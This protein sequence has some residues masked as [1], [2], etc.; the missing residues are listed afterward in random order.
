MD[1]LECRFYDGSKGNV[2]CSRTMLSIAN[3]D[4]IN[5]NGHDIYGLADKNIYSPFKSKIIKVE[6][7]HSSYGKYIFA[8]ILEG[9]FNGYFWL[10]AH[11][12]KLFVNK[13]NE[14]AQGTRIALEG[15]TG[16][17]SASHAHIELR[18][19]PG[20]Y[21]DIIDPGPITGVQKKITFKSRALCNSQEKDYR[22]FVNTFRPENPSEASEGSK[23]KEVYSFTSATIPVVHTTG[24]GQSYYNADI[25][26]PARGNLT[27]N[28]GALQTGIVSGGYSFSEAF[29]GGV[30]ENIA[31]T[32]GSANAT[33]TVKDF[34]E[35][36]RPN[37]EFTNAEST[38]KT[39]EA[40][41]PAKQQQAAAA[42]QQR[43]QKEEEAAAAV[44]KRQAA[45]ARLYALA[46]VLEDVVQAA[47][48]ALR[49]TEAQT[50]EQFTATQSYIRR[51]FAGLFARINRLRCPANGKKG[52]LQQAVE[53][54]FENTHR[55]GALPAGLYH[56][57]G[58]TAAEYGGYEA[59]AYAYDTRAQDIFAPLLVALGPITA[60]GYHALGLTAGQYQSYHLTAWQY[61]TKAKLLLI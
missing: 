35:N 57:L 9:G 12:D 5:H 48:Q 20:N 15:S 11:C 56:W 49:Q 4:G 8:Q 23:P 21:S 19:P 1:T 55:P 34:F 50:N 60:A 42:E 38:A 45:E 61:D 28:F 44:Q 58:L 16:K 6:E 47:G 41:R 27:G 22:T 33:A 18:R 46:N 43:A 36:T 24:G 14:V 30:L 53:W 13:D 51:G 17:S 2:Y 40:Q 39:L 32:N 25:A 52:T 3:N 37:A 59:G 29:V 31:L 54:L 26:K 7:N 10:V